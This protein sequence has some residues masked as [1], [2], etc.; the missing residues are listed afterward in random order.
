MT[1]LGKAALFV[2]GLITIF[3]G[4]TVAGR[5]VGPVSAESDP[6]AHSGHSPEVGAP[7]TAGPGGLQVS[8]GGYSLKIPEPTLPEGP[9]KLAVTVTGQDERPITTF[10]TAEGGQLHLVLVRRD[11]SGYQHLHPS[12]IARGAWTAPVDLTPGPYRLIATFRPVAAERAMALGIDLI[13]SGFF[14]PGLLPQPST[15]DYPGDYEAHLEG[16]ARAG[17]LSR[18]T[19]TARRAGTVATDPQPYQIGSGELTVLRVGDLASLR[20]R[21][22]RSGHEFDV[23]VPSPGTYRVFFDFT[24]RNALTTASFTVVVT[25]S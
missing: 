20:V 1:S 15:T 3:V 16:T 12:T 10:R 5:A 4:A 24:D 19:V 25:R 8:E 7:V 14:R 23:E 18:L 21:R 2:I 11:L 22:G 13:V 17:T 9:W 6:N